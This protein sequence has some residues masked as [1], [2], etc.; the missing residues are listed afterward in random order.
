MSLRIWS[1]GPRAEIYDSAGFT[2]QPTVAGRCL[3]PAMSSVALPGV[4]GA[5]GRVGSGSSG[6]RASGSVAMSQLWPLQTARG[7]RFSLSTNGSGLRAP[8][9]H[10]KL[11]GRPRTGHRSHLTRSQCST[12]VLDSMVSS[13]G[14]RGHLGTYQDSEAVYAAPRR[15]SS[16]NVVVVLFDDLGFRPRLLRGGGARRAGPARPPL[17]QLPHHDRARRRG[18]ACSQP[19]LDG[20]MSPTDSGWPSGRGASPAARR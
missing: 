15:R 18:R 8:R 6:G 13:L 19:S 11:R 3:C 17:Q 16:P 1:E 14:P 10:R 2:A 20:A 7:S 4:P 12:M 5:P 9:R